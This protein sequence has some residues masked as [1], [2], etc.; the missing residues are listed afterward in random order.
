[1]LRVIRE[2]MQGIIAWAIIIMLIIPF[3][4]WGINQYFEGGGPLVAATV[5]GEEISVQS[6]QQAYANQRE[7]MREMLGGKY[8]PVL[9]DDIAK[10]QAI[11]DLVQREILFQNAS[12]MG[13][14]VSADTVIQTI[15]SFEQFQAD[16]KFS[17][18]LYTRILQSQGESPV[19]FENRIQRSILT[20]Q[21]YSALS[22]SALVTDQ[23]LNKVLHLLEQKRNIQYLTLPVANYNDASSVTDD[24]IQSYY[25]THKDSFMTPEKVSI[26]YVEL[27]VADLASTKQ[28]TEEEL[29]QF[30]EERKTQFAVAEE[31]RTRHILVAVE[32]GADEA[33]VT[34]AHKKADDIKARIDKGEKF[35]DLAKEFSDDP[36]SS[37]LGGDL[38]YFGR[39]FMEPAFEDTMFSL[40]VG[41]VSA[42]VLTSFGFHIIKLEDIRGEKSK[43]F[44]EVKDEL[45][46]DYQHGVAEREFF[47]LS[48]KLTNLAYEVPDSLHDAAGAVN[49]PIKTSELFDKNGGAGIT[50]NPKVIAAAFSDDVLKQKYNSEPIEIAEN[51]VVVLR[52]KDHVERQQQT[53]DQ[54]KDQIKQQL[55]KD[56]AREKVKL[57]GEEI[58]KQLQAGGDATAIAKDRKLEWKKIDGLKRTDRSIDSDLVTKAFK[59]T[60]PAEGKSTIAGTQL[61]NGDFAVIDVSKV[62]AGDPQKTEEAQ[63]LSIKRN[64]VSMQGQS[65]FGNL[66]STLKEQAKIQIQQNNL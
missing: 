33:K 38:G 7:R 20:Q 5:N 66:L 60:K 39:G 51:H 6:Y 50:Q 14:R 59:M 11:D 45:I 55:V 46:R 65:D 21:L 53:L 8:D 43:S 48:E 18:E 2:S 54:V 31:R 58:V 49:L 15:Q 61:A 4:L 13:M 63:K 52:I 22:S 9:Y 40:K 47:A 17:H 44:E 42:P 26:E 1:M 62:E 10:K 24:A 27:N 34:A 37:K 57:A 32:Q 23:E 16:G 28:A 19:G 35:E 25:D 30:Y 56:A 64:L 29:R 12:D 3:A 41:E 36:G